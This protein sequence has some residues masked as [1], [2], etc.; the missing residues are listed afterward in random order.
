MPGQ[1]VRLPRRH[2]K[3][4][5][6]V[7][8]RE[9]QLVRHQSSAEVSVEALDQRHL[10][11]VAVHYRQVGGVARELCQLVGQHRRQDGA[12]RARPDQLRAPVAKALRDQ[13]RCRNIIGARV[14]DV[15]QHVGVGQ[16]LGLEVSVQRPWVVVPPLPQ[17]EMLHDI[18]HRKRRDALGVRRR[19]IDRPSVVGRRH[20]VDPLRLEVRQIS[21]RQKPALLLRKLQDGVG[22][23]AFVEG[24]PP[25]L[26]HQPQRSG[27]V[28]VAEHLAHLRI[29]P[30]RQ[31]D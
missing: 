25:L 18:Q 26:S 4:V 1:R 9:A 23:R 15:V 10:V 30:V 17:R 2:R 29:R 19:L 21:R 13:L 24:V 5:A 14:A 6:A 3:T 22:D 11:A 20:R 12:I 8:Q 28:R 27:K 16:R 7:L 31:K